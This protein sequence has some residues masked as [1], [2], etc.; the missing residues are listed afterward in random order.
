MATV[1]GSPETE[2]VEEYYA[3]LQEVCA[4]VNR[5]HDVDALCKGF[6]AR[7]AKVVE[8]EGDGIGR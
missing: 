2:T 4:D 7:L 5:R 3:R 1:P 6:R 8:K